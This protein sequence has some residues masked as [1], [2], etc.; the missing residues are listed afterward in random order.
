MR[1]AAL[2]MLVW[3]LYYPVLWWVGVK[4]WPAFLAQVGAI[5]AVGLAAWNYQRRPRDELPYGMIGLVGLAV[6][7]SSL[8]FGPLVYLPLLALSTTMIIMFGP[9]RK[10]RDQALIVAALVLLAPLILE[11][12]GV[13][14]PSYEVRQGALCILPRTLDV[15]SGRAEAA[16]AL[17]N[18]VVLFTGGVVTAR[19]R[20]LLNDA[21]ARQHLQAWQLRQVTGSDTS[22]GTPGPR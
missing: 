15:G 9:D 3:L 6:A 5:S 7:T 17:F 16:L 11:W 14:S 22:D 4:S 18:L 19:Y 2:G 10:R 1:M 21:E 20:N 13:M 8:A 12:A